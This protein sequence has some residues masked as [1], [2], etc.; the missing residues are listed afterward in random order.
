MTQQS[1]PLSM[2]RGVTAVLV[3]RSRAH[4]WSREMPEPAEIQAAAGDFAEG[5]LESALRALVAAKAI[6]GKVALGFHP[7]VEFFATERKSHLHG[8][9]GTMLETLVAE[10]GQDMVGREVATCLPA[11]SFSTAVMVPGALARQ[12]RRGLSKLGQASVR[13]ISTTYAVLRAAAKL[14]PRKARRVE[15]EIR[16]LIGDG[17]GMALLTLQGDLLARHVFEFSQAREFAV[18]SAGR[19][20]LGVARD[21][22]HC[23][24]EPEVVLHGDEVLLQRV[25]RELGVAGRC[26]PGHVINLPAYCAALAACAFRRGEYMSIVV[27]GNSASGGELAPYPAGGLLAAAGAIA[28][29]GFWMNLK[30]EELDSEI[31][32]LE[33]GSVEIFDR[34]GSDVYELRD[35]EER[36]GAAAY[37]AGSFVQDRVRWAPLLEE[38]PRLLPEGVAFEAF[39][40][41][42]PFFF[43]PDDPATP[44]PADE[45][46]SNRYCEFSATASASGGDSPPQ[47]QEFTAALRESK[48]MNAA[49]RRVT[50]A[51]VVL[52]HEDEFPWV[53]ARVRC[54]VR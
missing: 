3:G 47:V 24:T 33:T 20:L 34:F 11:D 54:L 44:A 23:I 46:A 7:E 36:L 25:C 38:F 2:P 17:Y 19:R 9:S 10:L 13:F 43:M 51:G 1:Q 52:H 42:F 22:L 39:E 21:S 5:E 31:R 15:A 28:V 49:F 12:A 14:E 29:V 32:N 16:I 48:V 30:S 8:K 41:S 26:A 53:E 50:G 40:G 45:V 18:I 27:A 37:L 4:Y 35:H 6:R